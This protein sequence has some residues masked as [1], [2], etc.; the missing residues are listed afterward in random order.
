MY[1][2]TQIGDD[3]AENELKKCIFST[4]AFCF[5]FSKIKTERPRDGGAFEE[6]LFWKRSETKSEFFAL[7]KNKTIEKMAIRCNL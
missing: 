3:T 1:L 5:I 6:G 2:V 4:N 7:S